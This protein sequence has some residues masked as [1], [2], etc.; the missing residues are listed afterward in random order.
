ME[1]DHI[2]PGNLWLTTLEDQTLTKVRIKDWSVQQ[3]I[4]FSFVSRST[5]SSGSRMVSGL[6]TRGI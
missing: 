1:Y 2:E 3:V 6:Y 5:G 4:P